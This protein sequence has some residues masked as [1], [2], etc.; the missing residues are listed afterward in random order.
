MKQRVFRVFTIINRVLWIGA[1]LGLLLLLLVIEILTLP[2][3]IIDVNYIRFIMKRYN[4][5]FLCTVNRIVRINHP[6]IFRYYVNTKKGSAD[7]NG[8]TWKEITDKG[9][10]LKCNPKMIISNHICAIDTMITGY[11]GTVMCQVFMRYIAKTSMKWAPII[12]WGM[13][14]SGSLFI[15]RSWD[16]DI[17]HIRKWCTAL[18]K[19][20]KECLAIYPEGTRYTE[21]K[22]HKARQYAQEHNLP[23]PKHLLI[24][25]KKGFKLCADIFL[26]APEIELETLNLTIIYTENNHKKQPP[27]LLKCFIGDVTGTFHIIMETDKID[28]KTN[29]DTYL[30][31][32]FIEKERLITLFISSLA[33]SK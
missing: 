3:T 15:N 28:S 5:V 32:M 29:L 13:Y 14:L 31:D 1:I 7:N 23:Q 26:K 11:I 9:T 22:R 27:S 4:K 17:E 24:P 6:N 16:K 10:I 25:R 8:I 19:S 30:N 20:Q 21:A 12:G 2:I 33:N 18:K